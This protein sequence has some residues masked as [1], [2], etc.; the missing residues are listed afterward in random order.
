MAAL[1]KDFDPATLATPQA[2]A[3]D[4]EL[5]T[6]WYDWRRLGC[7]AAEPNAGHMALAE[8]ERR[9]E[10]RGGRMTL[11][12]QNVDGL[13]RRAGS[14]NVVELHGT[15]MTWRCVATG[16]RVEPGG[17]GFTAFPP[18]SPYATGDGAILR[19]DVVWFGEAL[20]V[21]A[22]RVA[23]EVASECDLFLSVGTSSVVYPAAS[24][25]QEA[26]RRG[27]RT[28]EVNLEVTPISGMVGLS[29]RGKAGDVLPRVVGAME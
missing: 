29:I 18:V 8:I 1:W 20:P 10:A 5:V 12:T 15:I 27:A 19:P 21:E 3:R 17:E 9:I 24:F 16:R 23:S 26:A 4:P 25:I 13:H 11:L 2:F 28:A 22:V 7:L 14:R 6:R